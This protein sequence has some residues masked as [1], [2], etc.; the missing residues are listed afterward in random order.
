LTLII[1]AAQSFFKQYLFVTKS[2][3]ASYV[4]EAKKEAKR[5]YTELDG[6]ISKLKIVV[7]NKEKSYEQTKDLILNNPELKDHYDLSKHT[8]EIDKLKT[9]YERS[10]KKRNRIKNSIPTFEEYLKL[11]EMTPVV[12]SK[13][14]DM[15]AMDALLRIFFSNFTII[16]S[17]DGKFRGTTVSYKLNEPWKGFI[18]A[19]DFVSGAL[20]G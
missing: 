5:K 19:N 2:N 14:R 20:T 8:K 16:P 4:I 17:E 10:I 6:I 15:K 9:E 1:D 12:L 11:L 13:I 7:A 3:Y 18:D